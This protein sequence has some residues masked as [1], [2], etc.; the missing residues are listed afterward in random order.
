MYGNRP[1][2]RL[3]LK[4]SEDEKKLSISTTFNQI[5]ARM[6]SVV[7]ALDTFSGQ[8]VWNFFPVAQLSSNDT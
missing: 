1:S 8:Y 6:F 4:E 7:N 3:A 5:R 2:Y